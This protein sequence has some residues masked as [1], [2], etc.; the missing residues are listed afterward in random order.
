MHV[1]PPF[2]ERFYVPDPIRSPIANGE[3]KDPCLE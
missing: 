2:F 3:R 1:H